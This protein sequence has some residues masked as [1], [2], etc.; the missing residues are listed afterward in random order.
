MHN[1]HLCN[2]SQSATSI[3]SCRPQWRH[4]TLVSIYAEVA[5]MVAVPEF[6]GMD[7]GRQL[8]FIARCLSIRMSKSIVNME[9]F[10]STQVC[11][12]ETRLQISKCFDSEPDSDQPSS[13]SSPLSRHL[14]K[15]LSKVSSSRTLFRRPR[16]GTDMPILPLTSP[17]YPNHNLSGTPMSVS[18]R[19]PLMF[20]RLHRFQQMV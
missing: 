13:L 18:N 2:T 3:P 15:F 19:V 12:L 20:R 1:I 11:A 9:T 17:S 16:V 7:A 4:Q 5:E 14:S 6:N 10:A 8:Y